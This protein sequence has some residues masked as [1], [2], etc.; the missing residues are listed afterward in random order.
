MALTDNHHLTFSQK[1][2]MWRIM[3]VDWLKDHKKE[4]IKQMA[5][6]KGIT[7]TELVKN[8]LNETKGRKVRVIRSHTSSMSALK[9]IL[10][11]NAKQEEMVC[12]MK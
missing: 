9:N 4:Y 5:E 3:F 1:D 11:E 12:P 7:L 10:E 8:A 6:E 2:E